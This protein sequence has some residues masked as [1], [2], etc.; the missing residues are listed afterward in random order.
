VATLRDWIELAILFLACLVVTIFLMPHADA[1]SITIGDINGSYAIETIEDAVNTLFGGKEENVTNVPYI[2]QG[3][4][5]YLDTVIDIS[6]VVPPYPQLAYWDGYDMY[7]IEPEYTITLPDSK[8]GYYRFYINPSI[9]ASRIGRWYKYDGE[10]ESQGNNLAFIVSPYYFENRTLTYPNGTVVNIS[11]MKT[12]VNYTPHLINPEPLMPERHITDYVAARGDTFTWPAGNYHI[13]IFG[14][15]YGIYDRADTIIPADEI[16]ALEPG[17]YTILVNTP[18]NNTIY[19]AR[20]DE[21]NETLMPGLYGQVPVNINGM[22]APV[23]RD[24][25]KQ[26]LVGTDDGITEYAMELDFPYITINQADEILKNNIDVLDVRGYTNVANG[27]PITVTLDEKNT[28]Y[29]DIWKQTAKTV[30]VRTSPGNLSY[31]QAFV[32][33][34]YENLA[35]DARNHTLRATTALGGSME[36]DFK[37]SVM[38]ADSYRPNASLKYIEDRNPFVPT[39]TPERVEV[40]VTRTIIQTV[41]VPVTPSNEQV[42]EQQKQAVDAKWSEVFWIVMITLGA[43]AGIAA[44]IVIIWYLRSVYRRG[45]QQKGLFG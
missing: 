29:K 13:W 42:F 34:D 20:Y 30:A 24:K 16:N 5:V 40:V 8:R 2:Y 19:E 4:T 37:I 7:D 6:G 25:L 35:A 12:D 43:V 23:V 39:P 27:T 28:Y 31:Y 15:K 26:M 45:K 9:F 36:K 3:D 33:I 44:A 10:F 17:R 32:P 18:G 1:A 22:A 11:E 38:P 21:K 41:T 14:S